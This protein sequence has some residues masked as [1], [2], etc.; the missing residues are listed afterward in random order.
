MASSLVPVAE[1]TTTILV[2]TI[3]GRIKPDYWPGKQVIKH[4]FSPVV[5]H[6]IRIWCESYP[7]NIVVLNLKTFEATGSITMEEDQ[8]DARKK[9]NFVVHVSNKGKSYR[10]DDTEHL[11][12]WLQINLVKAIEDREDDVSD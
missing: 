1:E 7:S 9:P 5:P 12:F 10:V 4:D 2:K 6:V 11:P 8:T 3:T